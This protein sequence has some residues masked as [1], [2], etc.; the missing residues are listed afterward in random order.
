[1][2]KRSV[3]IG[4]AVF[5]AVVFVVVFAFVLPKTTTQAE[6]IY[7]ATS[8]QDPYILVE[9]VK[10]VHINDQGT[11]EFWWIQSG[12]VLP[13]GAD[14]SLVDFSKLVKCKSPGFGLEPKHLE[15]ITIEGKNY[16]LV[17]G[18]VGIGKNKIGTDI[19]LVETLQP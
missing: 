4:V 7:C 10:A 19:P 2:K 8:V 18:L 13:A 15:D 6:S 1:M 16:L 3:L 17:S 12:Y 14:R 5:L 11:K 9:S